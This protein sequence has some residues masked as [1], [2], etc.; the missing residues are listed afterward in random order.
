MPKQLNVDL[1]F[2]ADTSQAKKQIQDLQASLKGLTSMDNLLNFKGTDEQLKQALTTVTQL[3]TQLTDAFNTN[4][5]KL[6][7]TKFVTDMQKSGMSLEQYRQKLSSLGPEGTKAFNQLA[8][9]VS[10]ADVPIAR[11][12]KLLAEMGTVLKNTIKWQISSS[13]IHGFMGAIQ[14]AY[15]YAQ[16]LNESLT[17]IQIVTQ[18]S[19]DQMAAFAVQ[20]NN[21]ARAL[22]TTTTAYTDAALIFYQQG[23]DDQAVKERTDATIKMAQ[24]TGDA[25]TEVSSYMTAIWNNFDNG[26]ESL[27]HYADVITALGAA[28]ASSSSEI[29]EGL[30]KFASIADTVGLSYE[31]ATSALATVVAQ[32]RQ[33]ADVVGTAFKTIFARIQDLEQGATL[34]DGVDL[35]Q[36]AKALAKVGVDVL[37]TNGRL[38][39]MDDILDDIGEKWSQLGEAER[40]AL[41]QN[42]AGQRQY[43]QFM[44]IFENWDAF[45]TNL[46]TANASEGMLQKQADIYADSW[47]ASQKR[48]KAAMEGIYQ[49]IIDDKFFIK[50][51]NFLADNI[52]GINNLVKA[53]GGLPGVLSTAGA[54]LTKFFGPQMAQGIRDMAVSLKMIMPGG[55]EKVL[56]EKTNAIDQQIEGVMNASKGKPNQ[57]EQNKITI[58]T[59]QKQAQEELIKNSSKLTEE[60]KKRTDELGK[61]LDDLE[62]QAIEMQEIA[63]QEQVDTKKF[64][65]GQRSSWAVGMDLQ[66][67]SDKADGSY[68]TNEAFQKAISAQDE[69]EKKFN[70]LQKKLADFKVPDLDLGYLENLEYLD[71]STNEYKSL[72][73]EIADAYDLTIEQ[74]KELAKDNKELNDTEDQ[75]KNAIAGTKTET[76]TEEQAME[77]AARQTAAFRERLEEQARAANQARQSVNDHKIAS[78]NFI[79]TIR[80]S[81]L[82]MNDFA[83]TIV[84]SAQAISQLSMAINQIRGIYNTYK[85]IK[86]G[87]I[88]VADGALSILTSV[89]FL[90]PTI[91]SLIKSLK[92]LKVQFLAT[93]SVADLGVF[94]LLAAAIAAL[95]AACNYA[96]VAFEKDARAAEK[97]AKAASKLADAYNEAAQAYEDMKNTI[98]DYKSATEALEKLTKGTE[99][100]KDALIEANNAAMQLIE[101]GNLS[102]SDYSWEDGRLVIDSG[103]LT[104][105]QN[106]AQQQMLNAQ[107]GA[108]MAS[109]TAMNANNAATLTNIRRSNDGIISND[110]EAAYVAYMTSAGASWG[111]AVYDGLMS[112]EW[113]EESEIERIAER[114]Q[115]IGDAAYLSSELY[116]NGTDEMRSSIEAYCKQVE[117]AANLTKAYALEI[118]HANLSTEKYSEDIIDFAAGAYTQRNEELYNS[119]ISTAND[120]FNATTTYNNSTAQ[121]LFRRSGIEGQLTGLSGFSDA[122]GYIFEYIDATGEAK[123]ATL[124]QIA[125]SIAASEAI[126]SLGDAA[127]RA[128]QFLNG[129]SDENQNS[130]FAQMFANFSNGRVNASQ[131]AGNVLNGSNVDTTNLMN[132]WNNHGELVNEDQLGNDFQEV[133]DAYGITYQQIVDFANATNA[134]VGDIQRDLV[135]G[136]RNEQAAFNE[137]MS[138]R[139]T[140][141]RDIYENTSVGQLNNNAARTV[142]DFLESA[143]HSGAGSTVSQLVSGMSSDEVERFAQTLGQVDWNSINSSQFLQMLNEADVPIGEFEG[144][145]VDLCNQL[146]TVTADTVAAAAEYYNALEKIAE[147]LTDQSDTISAEDYASL[148]QNMQQYFALMLDGSYKLLI[149]ARDFQE[150]IHN[151]RMSDALDTRE[152]LFNNYNTL[153]NMNPERAEVL[154][155]Q[156]GS[157]YRAQAN[158]NFGYTYTAGEG[159]YVV[160]TPN[161]VRTFPTMEEAQEALRRQR[162]IAG[163]VSEEDYVAGTNYDGGW[164]SANVDVLQEKIDIIRQLTSDFDEELNQIGTDFDEA[165]AQRVDAIFEEVTT[166]E[167]IFD[168]LDARRQEAYDAILAQDTAIALSFDNLNDLREA[169]D[170]GIVATAE[171]YNMA[172]YQLDQAEDTAML[173]QEEWQDYADYIQEAADSIEDFNDEMSDLEADIVA[174]SIMKMNKAVETLSSNFDEW[175]DILTN[176]NEA[177]AEYADAL[178]QTRKTVAELLDVSEEYV[179]SDFITEHL[180]EIGAAAD[181]DAEA[182]DNLRDELSES[183][184]YR[185]SVDNNLDYDNFASQI[186]ELR[187]LLPENIEVGASLEGTDSFVEGLNQ[188][189]Q[190]TG[191]TVDQ[192]NA[193]CDSMGFEANFAEDWVET[194]QQSPRTVTRS[195]VVGYTR[196]KAKGPGDE[197]GEEW[198]MPIIATS[199]YQ[200]GYDTYTGLMP[201]MAM[202]TDGSVPQISGV[203]KKPGGIHNNSSSRNAG[204]KS[205]SGGGG[206]GKSSQKKKKDPTD[207]RERYHVINNQLEDNTKLLEQMSKAKDRAYGKS[208]LS[209]M[210]AEIERQRESIA[211]NEEKLRQVEEFLE[212]DQAAIRGFGAEF[213]ANGTITNYDALMQG[214]IDKYNAAVDAYNNSSMDENAEAVFQQAEDEY[215]AFTEA[216]KQYEETQDLWYEQYQAVADAKAELLSLQLQKIDYKVQLGVEW[217]DDDIE[218]LDFLLGRIEDDAYKA[219]EAIG[220]L[221][222]KATNALDKYNTYQQ[223]LAE[224]LSAIGVNDASSVLQR[225]M[226]G[227]SLVDMAASQIDASTAGEAI[228]QMGNYIS[229]MMKELEAASESIKDAFEQVK[230]VFSDSINQMDKYEEKIKHI[231]NVTKSYRNI[232]D[233]VGKDSLGVSNEILREMNAM[234]VQ[235]TTNAE[236]AAKAEMDMVQSQLQE[237]QARLAQATTEEERKYWQDL[238]KEQEDALVTATENFHQAWEDALQANLEAFEQNIELVMDSFSKAIGNVE[239]LKYQFDMQKSVKDLYEPDYESWYQLSNLVEDIDKTLANGEALRYQQDLL[240][241]EQEIVGLQEEGAKLSEYDLEYLR[242]RYE[243][244]L[245][246]AQ[247]DEAENAKSQVRMSRDNE[248]NYSYVYTADEDAVADAENNY[249]Q[250]LYEMEKANQEYIDNLQVQ[251]LEL[252]DQMLEEIS[253]AREIYG[254]DTAAL[255]QAIEQ[256]HEEYRQK[257]AFIEEQ[258]GHVFENN[259]RLRE[260]DMVSYYEYTGDVYAANVDLTENFSET[261]LAIQTGTENLQEFFE[262]TWFPALDNTFVNINDVLN[263]FRE[264]ED[265][266]MREAGTSMEDFANDAS[267]A[268]QEVTDETN[269]LTDATKK[270]GEEAV[271]RFAEA[272][273]AWQNGPAQMISTINAQADAIAALAQQYIAL[274][275]AIEAAAAAARSMPG[276]SGSTA[277]TPSSY[278]PSSPGGGGKSPSPGGGGKFLSDLPK[279]SSGPG[280]Y[281]YIQQ[282]ET[283]QSNAEGLAAAYMAIGRSVSDWPD[284]VKNNLRRMGYSFDTGGY[285]GAWGSDGR[286]AMLHE[287][288]LVLNADDTKNFLAA[289]DIVR[290]LANS[291]DLKAMT[292]NTSGINLSTPSSSGEILEQKV[293]VTANFPNVTDRNE[294]EEAFGNIINL[295]SQYANR[296]Q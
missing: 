152:A 21:A 207:E 262:G 81:S 68:K 166:T 193:L 176:S 249:R 282:L 41:A 98:S 105:A 219:A 2:N 42:V 86:D 97:T 45:K 113:A 236:S 34:E 67:R 30:S 178:I 276:S 110:I 242:L 78:Q 96:V 245:A 103:A 265:N 36:Y 271:R 107:A 156:S 281:Q 99:E 160:A 76:E 163:G 189:I 87:E 46:G 256:I 238:I 38:R 55:T 278:T 82:T 125:T 64:K 269:V 77:R 247:L 139:S 215:N 240:D 95:V 136:L 233:I 180:E 57:L 254:N 275:S 203:T 184:I 27:E 161:G 237:T 151:E 208:K 175:N 17:N 188:L 205:S 252:N 173:D 102:A 202:S 264:N 126:S 106:D 135:E 255:E 187:S 123:E 174:K 241:L 92:A 73:E 199:T 204:G 263:E 124:E 25:A 3:K 179:S 20:A 186:E 286:W 194:E 51:N 288:E 93:F 212:L 108:R 10:K 169:R 16:D 183:I 111:D 91:S 239:S 85:S 26:T 147:G 28:T 177:S 294:I 122:T 267:D 115:E 210:D 185:I 128:T 100:Y 259:T 11:T 66:K 6:D 277:Y 140:E 198:E 220:L 35:G 190:D 148:P 250:K 197:E 216:L 214:Q 211:L 84:K 118:A 33:S 134:A 167:G 217:E 146:R 130:V 65:V 289:V 5:G 71:H 164:D 248:G 171:A 112:S 15:G 243:S 157:N 89:G 4:T 251:L 253:R 142:L 48:V 60:E 120:A 191:M 279:I 159:N 196:G 12:N 58:Y 104:R 273:Q 79:E 201:V 162:A 154:R 229:E 69:Y 272:A 213:D 49:S 280:I 119:I 268:M 29:A 224:T 121:D 209:Y 75:L 94:A 63:K 155:N 223:G 270:Y 32:T 131:F 47:E 283:N 143:Q 56:S 244:K 234:T 181:G 137:Y 52:K 9:A 284:W 274:K 24:V 153:A 170:Q 43:A 158:N 74:T 206:G 195:E 172:A 133:L 54:L 168:N 72:L 235:Q 182:I 292:A 287:K 231:Q 37:D 285:T 192:V 101:N 225:A 116:Q 149:T 228:E 150:L 145:L 227:E 127:D 117:Q 39:E 129:I 40:V 14:Q 80:N 31:Y 8:S 293:E 257:G 226:S 290:S 83:A 230:N 291:I 50:L 59:Q 222:D 44:A 141:A 13:A 138:G 221:S 23:L 261:F 296:K 61:Q 1:R 114:Y 19:S 232:I 90:I 70:N 258:M 200:D 62:K 7:L 22:S 295:A 246:L 18:H 266:I 88:S 109:I 53:I 260:E 165:S 132:F 144:A 218:R